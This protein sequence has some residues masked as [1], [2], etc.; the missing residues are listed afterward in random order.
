[1]PTAPEGT[2]SS[3][4]QSVIDRLGVQ[5][6]AFVA[7]AGKR[8]LFPTFVPAIPGFR[9]SCYEIAYALAPLHR[10]GN[11]AGLV[12]P[13]LPLVRRHGRHAGRHL[14]VPARA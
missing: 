10:L 14:G 9:T 7:A 2:L 13:V 3:P 8:A 6:D 4:H 12:P 1:M 11:T 5:I